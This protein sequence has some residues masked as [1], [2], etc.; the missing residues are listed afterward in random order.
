MTSSQITVQVSPL[1]RPARSFE[2]E[3]GFP[4]S[5]FPVHPP[6]VI[7]PLP[8][9][10]ITTFWFNLRTYLPRRTIFFQILSLYHPLLYRRADDF[11]ML[12][13][14]TG[15]S[16]DDQRNNISYAISTDLMT[17]KELAA[18][19]QRTFARQNILGLYGYLV[20]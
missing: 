8:W 2:A 19:W 18:A 13:V 7:I 3:L 15:I 4:V 17:Y 1:R 16:P 14:G 9:E 10:N 6:G 20:L 5:V 12:G 11:I